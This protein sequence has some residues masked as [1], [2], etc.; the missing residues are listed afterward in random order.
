MSFNSLLNK[1]CDIEY[2]QTASSA[3]D[4]HPVETWQT[5]KSSVP[6]RLRTRSLSEARYS[7]PAYQEAQCALYV[8][9]FKY[10]CALGNMRVRF[11]AEVYDVI[12]KI[13]MGGEDKYFCLYLRRCV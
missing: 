11:G 4:G 5:L 8:A 12:G 3:D 6:C 13:N 2:C 10:S 7:A 1:T 9:A